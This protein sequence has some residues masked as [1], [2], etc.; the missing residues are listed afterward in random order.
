MTTINGLP[1]SNV[2]VSVLKENTHTE[3][4]VVYTS[5]ETY[6]DQIVEI[7]YKL[8]EM[9]DSDDSPGDI[10]RI[11]GFLIN[12]V[13]MREAFNNLNYGILEGYKPENN[14]LKQ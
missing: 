3:G 2:L 5:F 8:I 12:L 11:K 13:Y 14:M 7:T 10:D 6:S 9:L 4:D 1:I